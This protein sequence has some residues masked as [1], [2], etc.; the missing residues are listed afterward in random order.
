[1]ELIRLI[2]LKLQQSGVRQNPNAEIV[3]TGGASTL[4]G[5]FEMA[6]QYIPNCSMRMGTPT[7][8]VGMPKELTGTA[9]STGIGLVLYMLLQEDVIYDGNQMLKKKP[10]MFVGRSMD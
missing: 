5:L 1:M 8:L 6:Q 10:E 4:P 7:Q 9:F 2:D 3:M